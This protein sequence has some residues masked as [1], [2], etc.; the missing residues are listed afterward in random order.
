MAVKPGGPIRTSVSWDA[1]QL[2]Y[3]KELSE[4][5]GLRSVSAALRMVV[6]AAIDAERKAAA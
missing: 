2:A 1:A 3:L 5:H 4:R 6:N